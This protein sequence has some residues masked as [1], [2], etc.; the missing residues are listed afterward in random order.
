[1]PFFSH[2]LLLSVKTKTGVKLALHAC[3]KG[4]VLTKLCGHSLMD[5]D[6]DDDN[7]YYDDDAD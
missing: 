4:I 6:D 5:D 7:Y 3:K 1:M 2:R